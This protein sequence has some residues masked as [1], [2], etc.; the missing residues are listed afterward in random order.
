M[1]PE[2]RRTLLAFGTVMLVLLV[3]VLFA[4]I[5][6]IFDRV[7]V[8]Y[9]EE[10]WP[11]MIIQEITVPGTPAR[12]S[13]GSVD[14]N[15]NPFQSNRRPDI[16]STK[17]WVLN[18]EGLEIPEEKR[19]EWEN[20]IQNAGKYLRPYIEQVDNWEPEMEAA[21]RGRAFVKESWA[22][23]ELTVDETRRRYRFSDYVENNVTEIRP[24]TE[25]GRRLMGARHF[26]LNDSAPRLW[27]ENPV[28]KAPLP[29]NISVLPRNIQERAEQGKVYRAAYTYF[30]T[31]NEGGRIVE[32]LRDL[33][34]EWK[35]M[36][37][38]LVRKVNGG[39]LTALD[40]LPSY[41]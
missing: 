22:N 39:D 15:E 28:K 8:V 17:D 3:A 32:P 24:T 4:D 33:L 14:V 30:F 7:R 34:E 23:F 12:R 37:D 19:V 35:A 21:Q 26:Y 5:A 9:D 10:P 20:S 29:S 41:Y 40:D 2:V 18:L 11:Q 13:R 38:E 1:L 25:N 16:K 6:G 36:R 31:K 27:S